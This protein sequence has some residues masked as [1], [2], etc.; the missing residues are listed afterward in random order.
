MRNK[1]VID[2]PNDELRGWETQLHELG[3][4]LRGVRLPHGSNL[5][6][7]LRAT[8]SRTEAQIE[9]LRLLMPEYLELRQGVSVAESNSEA[10]FE[11]VLRYVNR[12]L[13]LL[14]S[15]MCKVFSHQSDFAS[16]VLPEMFCILFSELITGI[17]GD[18]EVSAHKDLIV[19][20]VFDAR[21]KGRTVFKKKRVDF[22]VLLPVDFCFQGRSILDFRIPVVAIEIKT[23]LDKNML[24][25]IEHSAESLKRTFPTC[26]Y[27]VAAEC[28]DF[29]MERQNYAATYID[30]VFILRKQKR[31]EKR[32]G[33]LNEIDA[34]L[35]QQLCEAAI[36]HVVASSGTL[37]ELRIRMQNGKLI[38][39]NPLG[40]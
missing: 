23:N 19:E 20:C 2:C 33:T 3:N 18:L 28:S 38:G 5:L 29:A 12:Y 1:A 39:R 36:S 32:R 16:S 13:N 11:L 10:R 4:H 22:A 7:K 34:A 40:V 17:D 30:E 27:A 37:G 9:A 24:A 6:T 14:H 21:E 26:F 25:A 8:S 15:P 35:V 31:A